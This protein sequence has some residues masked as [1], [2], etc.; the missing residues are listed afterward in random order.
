MTQAAGP[1]QRGPEDTSISWRMTIIR[2][3]S[4]VLGIYAP[5]RTC[6]G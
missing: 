5:G 3:T 4:A 1:G 2:V 6:R